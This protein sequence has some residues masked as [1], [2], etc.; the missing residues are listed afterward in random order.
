MISKLLFLAALPLALACSG[1]A[2]DNDD[3]PIAPGPDTVRIPLTDLGTRTYKGFMGGLYPSGSNELPNA[4][5]ARGLTAARAIRPLDVNGQPSANG[6]YVLMSMGMSNTSQEF[7]ATAGTVCNA[8][9]FSGKAAADPAVNH[10]TL[11]IANGAAG[12]QTADLWDS[13][14][15]AN[16]NRV[17]DQVLMPA[18][19]SEA[20]Q[21]IWLQA[22]R[23]QPDIALP[24]QNADAYI[25]LG[26]LG[27]VVRA[28]KTR[29]PNLRQIFVS[30][31]TYAGFATTTLNPEPYAYETAFAKK[32]LVEAQ[33]KQLDAGTI[34]A[35]AG[36]LALS[37]APW[38]AWGPYFWA[39]DSAQPRS[40]GFFWVRQDFENDG[41]HES[42]L[43]EEKAGRLLL[44]FF[45]TAPLTRCW[46]L[47]GQTC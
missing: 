15:D 16:Y 40:D 31:R 23:R 37:R 14:N 21:I 11:Y 2:T 26:W 39:G 35:R 1:S 25:L 27:D 36:D 7:C 34:D 13:P 44:E 9:T 32:W 4:H 43:G 28:A 12:G 17:R 5:A 38:L 24:N 45:K 41:T 22:V 3:Q 18:G 47:A 46:F 30:S 42:Q 19:L 20:Q 33:I 8:W 6:K 29:Y 10:T